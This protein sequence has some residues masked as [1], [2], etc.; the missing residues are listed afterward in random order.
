MII[1]ASELTYNDLGKQ[2]KIV[3]TAWQRKP[4]PVTY[5]HTTE[6]LIFDKPVQLDSLPFAPRT[7]EGVIKSFMFKGAGEIRVWLA[8][9][10]ETTLLRP[11]HEIEVI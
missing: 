5:N 3:S 11:T 2:I 1:K 4:L 8:G 7:R 10:N 6:Q 9:T